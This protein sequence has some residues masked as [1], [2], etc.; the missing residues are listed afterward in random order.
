MNTSYENLISFEGIDGCGKSTQIKLLSSYLHEKNISNKIV[1]EPG[2]TELA[3]KIR[4]LLLDKSKKI[5]EEEETLLFL[6][7]RA[8]LV[9]EFIAPNL[10][11]GKI[12]LCDRYIDSTVAYQGYGRGLNIDLINTFNKFATNDY[13]PSLTIIFD[14]DPLIV[15]QRII[16]RTLDRMEV[17]GLDF[18]TKIRKGYLNIAKNDTRYSIIE[19]GDKSVE[20]IHLEVIN[21]INKY[22]ER[23]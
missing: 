6:S 20:M 19:C 18:Q 8:S 21:L 14:I 23:T 16:N 10:N 3:E 1:R 13:S 4:T 11:K 7:A 9:N 17:E 15:H 5:N 22:L 12:V 2:G